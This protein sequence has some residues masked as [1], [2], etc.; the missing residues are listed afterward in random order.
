M[1]IDMEESFRLITYKTSMFFQVVNMMASELNLSYSHALK[2][3]DDSYVALGRL[4]QLVKREDPK[5]LDY[6]G[7]SDMKYVKPLRNPEHRYYESLDQCPEPYYPPYVSGSAILL[8]RKT[9]ECVTKTMQEA[10]FLDMEDVFLGVVNARCSVIPTHS[11]FVRVYRGSMKAS[12]WATE[13]NKQEVT[14][15]NKIIQHRI[16]SP[17]DMVAHHES[18]KTDPFQFDA[19]PQPSS[20]SPLDG[21]HELLSS[22][23]L[24]ELKEVES[25]A[26]RKRAAT[27]PRID[28]FL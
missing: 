22:L 27:T 1:W 2:T 17:E 12:R 10:R 25:S 9:V 28:S 6:W 13:H 18:T 7:Q 15:K 8:S 11:K 21:S 26:E 3:D 23:A 20:A 14:M 16:L 4:E 24:Q 5:H 19:I